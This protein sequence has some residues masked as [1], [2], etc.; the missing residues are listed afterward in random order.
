MKHGPRLM[1]GN[2]KQNTTVGEG[3]RLAR[4]IG[5]GMI[6]GAGCIV[7]PP[8]PH[9]PMVHEE[10][11]STVVGIGAQDVSPFASGAHTGDVGA[12]MLLDWCEYVLVGH[13]ERRTMYGESNHLIREKLG[14]IVDQGMTPI[15]AVGEDASVRSAGNSARHVREQL[16]GSLGADG[17]VPLKALVIAYEPLWAI[18][19]GTPADDQTVSEMVEAIREWGDS[20]I[21]DE[22][23]VTVLYGGSVAPSNAAGIF[24]ID[25]VDGALVGGSSLNAEDFVALQHILAGHV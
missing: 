1:V 15:L 17:G 2:W 14:R 19:T 7:L 8:F 24:A 3:V 10:L 12:D 22:T 5:A 6:A 11:K 4:Q 23:S 18:G 20:H 25:G 21:P 13:S 9:I 16:A